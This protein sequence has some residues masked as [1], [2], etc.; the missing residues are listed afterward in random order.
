[1][2]PS[3]CLFFSSFLKRVPALILVHIRINVQSFIVPHILLVEL[4]PFE[5]IF[6]FAVIGQ[7]HR[8]SIC[9]WK[10]PDMG[11]PSWYNE[12]RKVE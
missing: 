12:K 4:G 1:M 8:L 9:F 3:V 11:L 5:R 2:E 6:A 10:V 7:K